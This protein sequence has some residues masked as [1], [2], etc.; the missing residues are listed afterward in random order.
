MLV[1]AAQTR[2]L[3]NLAAEDHWVVHG[4]DQVRFKATKDTCELRRIDPGEGWLVD[5]QQILIGR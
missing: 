4:H 5:W 2:Y 3:Q 1:D